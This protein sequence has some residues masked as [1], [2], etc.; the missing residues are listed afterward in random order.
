MLKTFALP[1][2]EK[3]SSIGHFQLYTIAV[4]VFARIFVFVVCY[5]GSILM[6]AAGVF[7]A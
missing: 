6:E 7:Y 4:S 3:W 5:I 2:I 1:G